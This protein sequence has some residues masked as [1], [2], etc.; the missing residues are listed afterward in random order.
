MLILLASV[1]M[2]L[3]WLDSYLTRPDQGVIGDD[4]PGAGIVVRS[5]QLHFWLPETVRELASP[6]S[7]V[8]TLRDHKDLRR[9][10][11]SRHQESLR[12]AVTTR[13]Y[14]ANGGHSDITFIRRPYEDPHYFQ[15]FLD[16]LAGSGG[17]L[18]GN[19]VADFLGASVHIIS[20]ER[21]NRSLSEMITERQV[22]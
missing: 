19:T 17:K 8:Q 1:M 13:A 11:E 4:Y 21:L 9:F 12:Y 5:K 15:E 22:W 3:I 10:L 14:Q 16:I 7:Q 2:G 6:L 20:K 18:D